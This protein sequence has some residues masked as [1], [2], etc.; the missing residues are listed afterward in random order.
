MKIF[1][2]GFMGSGKTTLGKKLAR[3]LGYDFVDLDKVIEEESGVSVPDY[4]SRHGEDAFRQLE[5]DCLRTRL[6]AGPV[7]VATGGGAPCYFDNMDW[8]NEHGVTVYLMLPPGVLA[9]RLNGSRNRPLISG[10]SGP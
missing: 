5:R 7:V 3:V 2:I 6:P 8:M 4:F 10:L 1:L 9:S